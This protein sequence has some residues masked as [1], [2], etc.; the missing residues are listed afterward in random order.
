[1]LRVH[2]NR[3]FKSYRSRT[4]NLSRAADPTELFLFFSR[5]AFAEIQSQSRHFTWRFF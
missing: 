5:Q 2:A 1:M 4:L 3:C